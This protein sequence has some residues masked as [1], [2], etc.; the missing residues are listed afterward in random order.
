MTQKPDTQG[1]HTKALRSDLESLKS[2]EALSRDPEVGQA[3]PSQ[4]HLCS[5]PPPHHSPKALAT[6]SSLVP[7]E[8]EGG[9]ELLSSTPVSR[10]NLAFALPFQPLIDSGFDSERWLLGEPRALG[11]RYL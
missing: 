2:T 5:P 7:E 3:T 8:V 6:E 11:K 9:S 10:I 4:G 1:F